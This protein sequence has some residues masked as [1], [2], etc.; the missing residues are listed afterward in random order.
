[1]MDEKSEEDNGYVTLVNIRKDKDGNI[2]ETS[3]KTNMWAWKHPHSDGR[4]EYVELK[5]YIEIEE[6]G[7]SFI[8][9][10]KTKYIIFCY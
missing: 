5:G 9:K 10:K 7:K 4:L 1:M 8:I 3:E 6:D 2:F